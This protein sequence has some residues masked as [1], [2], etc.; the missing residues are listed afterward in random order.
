MSDVSSHAPALP[1]S[2][3]IPAF[4]EE[5]GISSTI[6][7]LI[8]TLSQADIEHEIVVVDDGSVDATA[9]K[10]QDA[11]ARVLSLPENRG[12][13]AA[14]KSGITIA[15]HDTIIIVDADGTYPAAALPEMLAFRD[16]Y[17]MVVG[18]RT[19]DDVRIPGIRRPAK[20]FLRRLAS[21]L[22]GRRIPDLNS[23]MRVM[24]RDLVERFA[25]V[26]PS[27]FSFTTSITLAALCSGAPV[28]Y[29]PINYRRR[30]GKSKMRA[31]HTFDFCSWF[32]AP[33]SI[34]TRSGYSCRSA[35]SCS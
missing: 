20:W 24:R 23:G 16:H 10:A 18:A 1:V 27:G 11:G 32:C 5:E 2:V 30:I 34:S 9:Q 35:P 8:S 17:D 3:V 21:Y 7:E 13:G 33:S 6:E 25:H 29:H 19:G 31:M 26:L 15:A 4:D 22:A 12:Y 28:R 14:V